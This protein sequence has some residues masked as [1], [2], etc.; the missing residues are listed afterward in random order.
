MA[1]SGCHFYQAT[2]VSAIG[3]SDPQSTIDMM[4]HG[5][6]DVLQSMLSLPG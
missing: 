1:S 3:V 4:M 2:Y 6:Q 5:D